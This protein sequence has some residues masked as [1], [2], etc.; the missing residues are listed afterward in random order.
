MEQ[1]QISRLVKVNIFIA[2]ASLDKNTIDPGHS[3]VAVSLLDG[4]VLCL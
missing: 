1:N 2:N 3:I 4:S